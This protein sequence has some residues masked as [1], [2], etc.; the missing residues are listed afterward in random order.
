M[1]PDYSKFSLR[2]PLKATTKDIYEAISTGAGIEKWF[3]AWAEFTMPEGDERDRHDSVEAG[4]RYLWKWFGFS[5]GSPETGEVLEANGH[6]RVR[7]TFSADCIVTIAILNDKGETIIEL[8]QENIPPDENLGIYLGCSSGW[9][10]YLTNLK[11]ILEGGIDLRNKNEE[12][13]GVI[14]A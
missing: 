1:A 5:G 14:N 13:S 9:M 11:S 3:L 12:L 2:I 6:D 8:V 7:F 10:F 4:D